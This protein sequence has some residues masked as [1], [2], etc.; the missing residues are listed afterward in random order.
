M[1]VSPDG[2]VLDP[3]AGA[4]TRGGSSISAAVSPELDER[5]FAR[6]VRRVLRGSPTALVVPLLMEEDLR[7]RGAQRSGMPA[8][9]TVLYPFLYS[10]EVDRRTAGRLAD[11]LGR[12]AAFD[13]SLTEIRSFPGVVYLSPEPAAPFVALTEVIVR[14]WPSHPPYGGAYEQIVPHLTVSYGDAPPDGLAERLPI[15]ARTEEVWLMSRAGNRWMRRRRF[16]LAGS[17]HGADLRPAGA[18][19]GLEG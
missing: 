3:A 7:D 15:A 12:I 10:R 19:E 18:A 1:V 5:L 13:F 2:H 14:A 6:L 4:D 11:M 8:H 17:A 16:A 9:I